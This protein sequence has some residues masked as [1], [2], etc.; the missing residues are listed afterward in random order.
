MLQRA[1]QLQRAQH[2]LQVAAIALEGGPVTLRGGGAEQLIGNRHV[3]LA[4]LYDLSAHPLIVTLGERH[5]TQQCI[6]DAA[7]R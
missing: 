6:G 4:Q 1:R 3:P 2:L 5:Q 7:A